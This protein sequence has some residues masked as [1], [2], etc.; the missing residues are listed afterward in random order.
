MTATETV[1]VGSRIQ[2]RYR[3]DPLP[4]KLRY[5]AP[6]SPMRG[7]RPGALLARCDG[8]RWQAVIDG[9][10]TTA[11]LVRLERQHAGLEDPA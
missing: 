7:Y 2:P 11:D 9:G 6:T 5:T 1:N 8:C 10:H 4:H 3:G